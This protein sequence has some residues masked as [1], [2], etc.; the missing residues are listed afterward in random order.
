MKN[1]INQSNGNAAGGPSADLLFARLDAVRDV[2][3]DNGVV[4]RDID[5]ESAPPPEGVPPHPEDPPRGLL[6][7]AREICDPEAI[8][9]FGVRLGQAL[10]ALSPAVVF[11]A[12]ARLYTWVH[13][14]RAGA[15]VSQGQRAIG[16]QLEVS[17]TTE[18]AVREIQEN[19]YADELEAERLA[20]KALPEADGEVDRLDHQ[21]EE[22]RDELDRR[23]EA[24]DRAR[25][26][27]HERAERE[28]AAREAAQK[29]AGLRGRPN[30]LAV[31]TF[32]WRYAK[33]VLPAEVVVFTLLLMTPVAQVVGTSWQFGALLAAGISLTVLGASTLIGVVLAA[34]RVPVW[35]VGGG[36][37]GLYLAIMDRFVA[38][39]T[40][41]RVF[42]EAGAETL[43]AATLA[44]CLVAVITGYALAVRGA[45]RAVEASEAD[46]ASVTLMAS[47]AQVTRDARDRAQARLEVLEAGLA[48][49]HDE[50]AEIRARIEALL[51][52]AARGAARVEARRKEAA[53]AEVRIA[54]IHATTATAVRQER[55]AAESATEIA[56][57]AYG[58]IRT[59]L[60]GEP[61]LTPD[62]R[63]P[64]LPAGEAFEAS[65]TPRRGGDLVP[66][67]LVALATGGFGYLGIGTLGPALGI[68]TA[69]LLMLL[70]L[71]PPLRRGRRLPCASGADS[72]PSPEPAT[73]GLPGSVDSPAWKRQPDRTVTKYR[74]GDAGFGE[75]QQ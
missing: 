53:G 14:V 65:E 51:N 37:V 30:L 49:A 9:E 17:A 47:P 68:G 73:I 7:A 69:A 27:A 52:S 10:R 24:L 22:A 5:G 50:R 60:P 71:R 2:P 35:L 6:D 4:G 40:A 32:L 25:L 38:G 56:L 59:E 1:S 8:R 21:V 15:E 36:F 34:I 33:L 66:A 26:D 13:D 23:Q 19:A 43:T 58:K 70:S 29:E 42:D 45:H 16:E 18:E 55:A 28:T 63:L 75:G 3:R 48:K 31:L 39:L 54:T 67:A 61:E 57:L 44:A 62:H 11:A 41:L 20:Y 64:Q 46:G 12:V 72:P 74:H